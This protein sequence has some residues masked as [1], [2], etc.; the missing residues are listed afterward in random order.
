MVDPGFERRIKH[1]E[2]AR[3]RKVPASELAGY[4]PEGYREQMR[5]YARQKRRADRIRRA[6]EAKISDDEKR[7]RVIDGLVSGFKSSSC[8]SDDPLKCCLC[9]TMHNDFIYITELLQKSVEHFG[10]LVDEP[11]LPGAMS[12]EYSTEILNRYK[13]Y[14]KYRRMS[15]FDKLAAVAQQLKDKMAGCELTE[16]EM[17][18]ITAINEKIGGMT[19]YGHHTEIAKPNEWEIGFWNTYGIWVP[20]YKAKSKEEYTLDSNRTLVGPFKNIDELRRILP[21]IR[22]LPLYGLSFEAGEAARQAGASPIAM[23]AQ[24]VAWARKQLRK[25]I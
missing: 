17:D 22:N 16:E 8:K 3:R 24:K 15:N 11:T 23:M 4:H 12:G 18:K 5:E 25:D 1:I 7:Q 9:N 13:Y 2:A 10:G 6:E 21:C 20:R 19:E 14:E